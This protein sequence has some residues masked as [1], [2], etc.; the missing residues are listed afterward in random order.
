M[1]PIQGRFIVFEGPDGCGKGV[2]Q[3]LLCDYLYKHPLDKNKSITVVRTREPHN[4]VYAVEIR[5][6]LSSGEGLDPHEL[7][8]LFVKDRHVHISDVIVPNVAV[9]NIV[10]SD[11]YKYSTIAYQ[12]VKGVPMEKLFLAH[13][14]MVV[15]DLVFFLD[16]PASVRME[17]EGLKTGDAFDRERDFQEKLDAKYRE[18]KVTFALEPIHIIDGN[19]PP[20]VVFEDIKKKVDELMFGVKG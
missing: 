18:L 19:R 8:D 15:P 4:T 16:V 14:G 1:R 13:E 17:R 9:G 2:Q 11:R 7:T 10:V 3:R 12:G 20:E 5:K 6:R